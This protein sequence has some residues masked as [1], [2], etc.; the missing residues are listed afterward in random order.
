MKNTEGTLD[1]QAFPL[2]HRTPRTVTAYKADKRCSVSLR[3]LLVNLVVVSALANGLFTVV[4][5][6]TSWYASISAFSEVASQSITSQAQQFRS[7]VVS[8]AQSALAEHLQKSVIAANTV[9][10]NLFYHPNIL[11]TTSMLR[12]LA[13][14]EPVSLPVMRLFTGL[15]RTVISIKN[16]HDIHFVS[17]ERLSVERFGWTVYDRGINNNS[18]T[19]FPVPMDTWKP[20]YR[21]VV[22][23]TANYDPT[24]KPVMNAF[25]STNAS[26]QWM[27]YWDDE[28]RHQQ[29]VLF[30]LHLPPWAAGPEADGV[31]ICGSALDFLTPFF[32]GFPT[33]AHGLAFLFNNDENM[34][35]L[36]S[37]LGAVTDNATNRPYTVWSHPTTTYRDT[38]RAWLANTGGARDKASFT[39]GEAMYDV[40]KV[41]Q[42]AGGTSDAVWWIALVSP[43][44]DFTGNV[45]EQNDIEMANNKKL[46][47]AVSLAIGRI[48]QHLEC[49]SK[50]DFDNGIPE[51]RSIVSEIKDM[52]NQTSKMTIALQ[53][54]NV[55]VP[56]AI[57]HWL[58]ANSIPPVISVSSTAATVLFLDVVNFTG[59]MESVGANTMIG[60]LG[61]MFEDFSA[62]LTRN[63]GVID[64]YIG[65]AIM[66]AMEIRESLD[67]M[68][69]ETFRPEMGFNMGVRIGISS[70][71]VQAG[72]I[73][74][75]SRMNYT[76]LG[77]SVNLAARLEPLNK[78]LHTSVCVNDQ[79]R[80]NCG[81]KAVFRC[82]GL[83]PCKGFKELIPI[84]KALMS[85]TL[86]K[87]ELVAYIADHPEDLAPASAMKMAAAFSL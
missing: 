48:N 34:T 40:A 74:S 37:T 29:V 68:N 31:V 20:N 39:A 22:A 58:V 1:R 57:V 56:S 12:D 13:K 86:S 5:L 33:S 64:K 79:V 11:N 23:R 15:S 63:K 26:S 82:I 49:V 28:V 60:I 38:A 3:I 83:V 8:S 14:F 72:N 65:D 35:L 73:G 45:L 55:Y 47:L 10:N 69:A 46:V 51:F 66:S 36:G 24:G 52:A 77:D 84:D 7:V 76:V 41:A 59:M 75:S 85:D 2:R 21:V 19:T 30:L 61:T 32:A 18:I 54:F 53:T 78:E 81:N 44:K 6:A 42:T 43:V 67:K 4:P 17:A 9:I 62:T 80:F 27:T 87:E 50:M 16:R 25:L 70:G 71:V